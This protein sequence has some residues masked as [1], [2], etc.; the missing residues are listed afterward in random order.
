MHFL[1]KRERISLQIRELGVVTFISSLSLAFVAAIWAIYMESIIHNPSKV[2]LINTLFG[3]VGVISLIAIIPLIEKNSKTRILG[4]SLLVYAGSYFLFSFLNSFS[5][6][7][8]IGMVIAISSSM[9]LNTIGIILRDKSGNRSVSKNTSVIYTLFNLSWLIGPILAG[10]LADKK[11]INFVFLIA[12]ILMVLSFITMKI[13]GLKDNRTERKIDTNLFKLIK[14]FFSKKKFRM[15]YFISGGISFWWAFIYIYMPIFIIK[16]G[17]SDLLVGYFLAGVIAPLIFLEYPFGK[18]AGKFGFKKMF[19]RGYLIMMIVGLLCFFIS[20][21]Y[22]ILILLVIGSVGLA[23]LEPTTE[24]YFFDVS[25]KKQ[26]D[27]FYGVYNTTIDIN[28]AISMFII[29]ILIKFLPFKYSFLLLGIVMAF[30]VLI[31]LRVTNII[32]GRRKG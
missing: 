20:N 2:G 24:A 5:A 7:L 15:T 28:Q 21:L 32:E 11:G 13:F 18:I 14:E 9:R 3:V 1:K 19:F 8:I 27:R 10:F 26:R 4:I 30:F 25:T 29:A 31:S 22:I 12:G 6:I 17:K 16:S 23:M